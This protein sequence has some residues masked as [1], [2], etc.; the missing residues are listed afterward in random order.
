MID[1]PLSA[2][3]SPP[4]TP[5]PTKCRPCSFSLASR[6]IVS[7]KWALPASMTMSPSSSSGISSSMTASVPGPGLDHD[8][9]PPGL[10]Q[11]G[12]EV[13]QRLRGDEGA[14]GAG[15]GQ[16]RLGLGVGPVVDRHPVPAPGEVAR[17]VPPHYGQSGHP[18]LGQLGQGVCSVWVT[19]AMRISKVSSAPGRARSGS[20][21]RLSH[22]R[23]RTGSH[24]ARPGSR[25]QARPNGH[26]VLRWR[27][28]S[29]HAGRS[30]HHAIHCCLTS[31]CRLSDHVQ[32][33]T[34]IGHLDSS[35]FS[36]PCC[37][38]D[39]GRPAQ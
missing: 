13:G 3:S 1:G 7:G 37:S 32:P 8:Q 9:D 4:D 19:S 34:P 26:R 22:G 24:R 2:P 36:A 12:H 14:L 27:L 39:A 20:A 11:R 35:S 5:V 6:R 18:D 15:V 21:Y 30:H 25:A 10:L 17:Q 23:V 28:R 31:S 16:Q 38:P 29:G 33:I